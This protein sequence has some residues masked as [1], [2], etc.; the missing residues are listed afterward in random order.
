MMEAIITKI[1][2]LKTV[3]SLKGTKFKKSVG[4][5]L[6]TLQSSLD[7]YKDIKQQTTAFLYQLHP[8]LETGAMLPH[9]MH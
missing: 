5:H 1:S 3:V 6:E 7:K 8:G 2:S 4:R 9:T